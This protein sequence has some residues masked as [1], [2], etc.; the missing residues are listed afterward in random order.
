MDIS[1]L[2]ATENGNKYFYDQQSNQFFLTHPSLTENECGIESDDSYYMKKYEY[3]KDHGFFSEEHSVK[4]EKKID[5][6]IIE[7]G[8]IQSQQLVFET[9]DHCNLHCTYCS[10][11]DMYVFNKPGKK[12]IDTSK[13]LLALEYIFKRKASNSPFAISFFG[14]EPLYNFD[15]IRVIINRA[16]TLNQAKK[17]N[18]SFNMT[19]NATLLHKHIAFL[20]ENDV[21]LLVSLDGDKISHSYRVFK[22]G[23]SSFEKVIENLDYIQQTYPNYFENNISFNSVLHDKNSVERI[24]EFCWGKYKKIPMISPLNTTFVNEQKKSLLNTMYRSK[25]KS[26]EH[27]LASNSPLV[28]QMHEKTGAYQGVYKF[29]KNYSINSYFS[30]ILSLLYE[31]V[32][33]VPTG[34]CPPFRRKMFMNTDN[35]LL[36]CEKVSYK[37]VLGTVDEK[38]VHIDVKGIAKKFNAY[39]SAINTFCSACYNAKSCPICLLTIENVDQLGA[40]GFAC[41]SFSDKQA[42]KNRLGRIFTLLERTPEDVVKVMEQSIVD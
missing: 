32:R 21:H 11:G 19:T 14:G 22:D 25:E 6:S 34:T 8:I 9:T 42:F 26:E 35:Q 37:H 15:F 2:F 31:E 12:N 3:L 36:P 4:F 18:L 41:P 1:V 38:G 24:Y 29:M 7:E 13:A 5:E 17:L 23:R 16:K 27:F 33:T 10:L 28:A 30:N 20:V 40:N 39:Y